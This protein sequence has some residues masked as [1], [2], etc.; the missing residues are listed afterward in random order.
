MRF[1]RPSSFKAAATAAD[2]RMCLLSG[3]AGT[4]D[5]LPQMPACDD[6]CT[7]LGSPWRRARRHEIS[8]GE[9]EHPAGD[10][11]RTGRV[12]LT[13]G[14]TPRMTLTENPRHGARVIATAR[15]ALTG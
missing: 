7:A 9:L 15:D 5:E 11:A 13:K 3:Q 10:R 8:D 1:A 12:A 14:Q 2:L 4:S 6:D